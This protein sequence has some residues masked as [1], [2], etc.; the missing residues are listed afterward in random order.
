MKTKIN[1]IKFMEI[2]YVI[3]TLNS[4]ST[5]DMT[6][7]SLKHQEGV[8]VNI[9][10]V[11]SGSTDG[12]LDI[13]KHWGVESLYIEPGN[14]YKAINAGINR[15]NTEWVAY[16]NSDDWLYANSLRTMIEFGDKESA[17]LVYGN[18]DHVDFSGRLLYS[19]ASAKPRDLPALFRVGVLGF[20][21]QTVIFRRS[22]YQKLHG[23][24]ESYSLAAD[25]NFFSKACKMGAK[26]ANFDGLPIA[27][28]RTHTSQLSQI[29]HDELRTEAQRSC[30]ELFN[31]PRLED[32]IIKLKWKSSNIFHYGLR[33]LRQSLLFGRLVISPSMK[34][35]SKT[36]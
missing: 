29:K 24:D 33:V 12:T 28:F 30:F 25:Y 15:F 1:K 18:C 2:S 34:V 5:L 17:D 19:F 11:D 16:L 4:A 14:I 3:P 35:Y 22:L 31:P 36:E 8:K 32:R 26:F 7:L 9:L 20:A 27:C 10:V 23:F 21:Q 13:C 6:I